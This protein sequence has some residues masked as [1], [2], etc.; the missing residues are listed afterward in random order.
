M[1]YEKD[2]FYIRNN[3]PDSFFYI[4]DIKDGYMITIDMHCNFLNHYYL[5]VHR[6]LAK[7]NFITKDTK[8]TK[9]EMIAKLFSTEWYEIEIEKFI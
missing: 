3:N 6:G 7:S 2:T 1:D 8:H 5:Y 4:I 9:S